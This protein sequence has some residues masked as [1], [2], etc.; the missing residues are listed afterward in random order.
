MGE[1]YELATDI[2]RELVYLI[3]IVYVIFLSKLL[4]Y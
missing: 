1:R 3:D 4:L 2:P